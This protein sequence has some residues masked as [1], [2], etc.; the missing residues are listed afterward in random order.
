MKC[1]IIDDE[2]FAIDLLRTYVEKTDSLE[3]AGTFSNPV[4]A[5]SFL[6]KNNIDLV[7]LDINMP[8]LTGIQLIKSLTHCPLIIFTTAYSEYGVESYEYNVA[9]YLLKPI[10]Y[11]RFLKAITKAGEIFQKS[12]AIKINSVEVSATPQSEEILLNIKS[13]SKVHRV[14]TGSIIY[15]EAS[16]NYMI[17]HTVQEKIMSLLTMKEAI[18]LLPKESFARIHK[19]YIVSLAAIE[20]IERHQV[21]IKGV[22][23]PVGSSYRELFLSKI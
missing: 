14:G 9:D 1:I 23:L 13:G 4:K 16:G 17:F 22:R 6:I 15:V 7:F 21:T 18:D 12:R 5:H 10:R 3:L 11:D 19:S 20:T 2:P 8:E